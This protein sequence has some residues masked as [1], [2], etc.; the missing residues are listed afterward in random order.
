MRAVIC[1]R[2]GDP[3][4]ALGDGVLKLEN[5]FPKPQ[6]KPGHLRIKVIAAS[7]NFPDALLV[8]VRGTCIDLKAW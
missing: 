4:T 2:L 1:E 6:L 3:R 5:A 8:K 7:L